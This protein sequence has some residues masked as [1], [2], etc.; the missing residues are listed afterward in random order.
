MAYAKI[1]NLYRPEAHNILDFKFVYALEKIHGTSA[2]VSWDGQTNALTFF[3]GGTNH[4]NFVDFFDGRPYAPTPNQLMDVFREFCGAARVTVYGEAYGGKCQGMSE[5]YGKELRF[6]AF[7][8]KIDD[9]W[10]A[11]T[12]AF[13]LCMQLHLEF[14]AYNLVSTEGMRHIDRER[15]RPSV[16]AARN[17]MGDNRLREGVVLRPP[18]EVTT[19]AGHRVCAKHKG[20]AFQERE[21]Q[22]RVVDKAVLEVMHQAEEV[23]NEWVTPMRLTHVLDGIPG[24]RT[25]QDTGLVIKEMVRDVMLE[26][27][28]EIEDTKAV[29]RA[30]GKRAAYLYKKQVTAVQPSGGVG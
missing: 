12:N 15:D 18:F 13:N 17:G 29:R 22:P 21:N 7:D 28:G 26:G 23:A 4:T 1:K 24:P 8:V 14:V 25:I 19:N 3:S 10:L 11:V 5:T 27:D 30:I 16:Q 6:V 20:E 9:K 2:N